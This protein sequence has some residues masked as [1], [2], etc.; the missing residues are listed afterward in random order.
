MSKLTRRD[1][2]KNSL[3]TASGIGI[4]SSLPTTAWSKVLGANDD[5]RVAVAG[6]RGKGR[7]H[8]EQFRKLPGVRVVAVCDADQEFIDLEVKKFTDSNE[9]VDAYTDIR[10]LLEDKNIDAI[11]IATPNHWHSLMTIWG[12]QAGKDV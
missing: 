1:F 5:V 10:K 11:V 8:I 6:L 12:C 3:A 9:K 2:I 7:S 4:T